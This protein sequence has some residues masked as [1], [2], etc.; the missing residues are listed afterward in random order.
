LTN[1]SFEPQTLHSPIRFNLPGE[2][3]VDRLLAGLEGPYRIRKQPAKTQTIRIYDTFDWRLFKKSL[4]LHQCDDKLCLRRLSDREMLHS[5]TT[6]SPPVFAWDFPDGRLKEN[7]APIIGPRA[8]LGLAEVRSH[9]KPYALL[10]KEGKTVVRLAFEETRASRDKD[11]PVLSV[12]LWLLPVK[13]YPGHYR[14]IAQQF[15]EAGFTLST[16]DPVFFEALKAVGLEPG[17]YS[18]KVNIHL[19]PDMRADEATKAILRFLARVIRINE[20][21]IEEDIDTEFIHDFRVAVR[22]T[23]S[24]LGQI[25]SVFPPKTTDRFR[26]DFAFV[27]KLSNALR[28]LDVYLLR[29][30]AYKAKIA[31]VLRNDI[32]PLFEFLRQKRAEAFQK[33]VRGLRS[34]R[35][36]RSMRDWEAFLKGPPRDTPTAPMAGLPII[37]LAC[38]KVF[39]KYRRVVKVGSGLLEST[40]DKM[41]HVLRIHCKKLRYLMEFFSS[42]FPMEKMDILIDQ[43]KRLQD[44]LGDINDLR[45]QEEYLLNIAGGFPAGRR[46]HTRT[47]LAIGSLIG[48]LAGDRQTGKDAFARTFEDFTSP[49]NSELFQDLFVGQKSGMDR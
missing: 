33:A 1:V 29:E 12:H 8:L 31:S 18:S 10:D 7:L 4:V 14:R 3:D 32:D 2:C 9:H 45:V 44:N 23:R 34:E 49:A 35:Y 22:R 43:L 28:D 5:L 27:G 48:A 24:A 37:T 17:S 20:A 47:L 25:R 21:H 42:L 19:H 13:G 16:G 15:K 36:A 11:A 26:R 30:R 6:A 46:Q 38:K 39:R 40:D 41:L